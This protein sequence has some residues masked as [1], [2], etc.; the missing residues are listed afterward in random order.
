[1]IDELLSM[2]ESGAFMDSDGE[3][4]LAATQVY[5]EKGNRSLK[6][7]ISDVS[8]DED[9]FPKCLG[10]SSDVAVKTPVKARSVATPPANASSSATVQWHKKARVQESRFLLFDAGHSMEFLAKLNEDMAVEDDGEEQVWWAAVGQALATPPKPVAKAKPEATP[11][12]KA[13]SKAPSLDAQSPE[14]DSRHGQT[15]TMG[16]VKLVPATSQTYIVHQP[17]GEKKWPLVVAVSQMQSPRHF[18][19]GQAIFKAMMSDNLNKAQAVAKRT[20]LLEG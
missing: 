2:L 16:R 13:E 17:V 3:Q 9:G 1:M 20:E 15:P 6:R 5:S 14:E 11:T 12:A 4:S 19:I 10:A 18:E 7:E 8:L